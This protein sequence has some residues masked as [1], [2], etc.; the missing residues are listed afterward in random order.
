MGQP[1]FC[2]AVVSKFKLVASTALLLSIDAIDA[3]LASSPTTPSKYSRTGNDEPDPAAAVAAADGEPWIWPAGRGIGRRR[4]S[5]RCFPPPPTTTPDAPTPAR[6][7]L[8]I[9]HPDDETMFFTPVIADM[10]RRGC[11]L[12]LLCCSTGA[13][14]CG[15]ERARGVCRGVT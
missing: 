10:Q 13:C 6:V 14:V 1:L 5:P 15:R 2:W 7:L 3:I 9:A 11:E 4:S 12:F 8:V